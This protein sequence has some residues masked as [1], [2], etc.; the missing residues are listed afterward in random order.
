MEIRQAE[1]RDID[2]LVQFNINNA[3]ETEGKVL[4]PAAYKGVSYLL[5][6][7]SK[8]TFYVAEIN[9]EVVGCLMITLQWVD[10]RA[11]YIYF[12]Q[13]VY[14]KA[15]FRGRGVFKALYTY[16]FA[17]AQAKSIA[18]RLY[19]D[20]DNQRAIDVY[21]KLGMQEADAKFLAVD[22]TFKH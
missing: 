3:M 18:L 22:F 2:V 10:Y 21:K 1:H 5:D 13:S 14:T 20:N 11:M 8:G 19:A 7:P 4:P 12:I 9:N 17:I 16:V 6:N 15:E